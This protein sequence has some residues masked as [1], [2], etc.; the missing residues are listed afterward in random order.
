MPGMPV[1][2]A[3]GRV[4]QRLRSPHARAASR[5]GA[6]SS[7]PNATDPRL[8]EALTKAS[9]RSAWSEPAQSCTRAGMPPV[10]SRERRVACGLPECRALLRPADQ[11]S[12]AR[13]D[14]EAAPELGA[15]CGKVTRAFE[16]KEE[17]WIWKT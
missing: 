9:G 11:P 12:W 14:R 7:Q 3:K 8:C 2:Q 15:H 4:D 1:H 13:R 10:T 5:R 16:P 17:T 6:D